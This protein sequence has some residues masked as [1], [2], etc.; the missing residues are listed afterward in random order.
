MSGDAH[1]NPHA[2]LSKRGSGDFAVPSLAAIAFRSGGRIFLVS[3]NEEPR[4]LASKFAE[5]VRERA[6]RIAAGS[7]WKASDSGEGLLSGAA[8][9]GRRGGDP[10]E[11]RIVP[12]GLGPG[13]SPGELA[14]SLDT[15]DVSGVFLHDTAT[16]EETRLYHGN[17]TRVAEIAARRGTTQLACSIREGDGSSHI[18]LLDSDDGGSPRAVTDGDSVDEAPNWIPGR[19]ALVFQ[20]AG[21][22]RTRSGAAAGLGPYAI[23]ELDLAS[24]RLETRARDEHFDF[25]TPRVAVDGTLYSLRRPYRSPGSA[26]PLRA[27]WD[28]VLFP[29]RLLRA[30]LGWLDLF[31]LIYSG[32]RLTSASGPP[33]PEPQLADLVVWGRRI[34]AERR[35]SR[36]RRG[37]DAPALVPRSWQLVRHGGDGACEVVADA[38]LAFDLASDGALLVSNGSA[39]D[40]IRADGSRERVCRAS[41]IEAVAAID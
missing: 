1:S 27:L 28:A 2:G 22:G 34:A 25:L 19:D 37:D 18:A 41:G 12:A 7:D 24:G 26:R 10:G 40:R 21:I 39:I 23:E 36:A 32:K 38:V 17:A 31:S 5:A 20:S 16:G 11:V 4:E 30:L 29:L 13:R 33:R 14:Y 6:R 9:W 3:S 8:L 15:G 35:L